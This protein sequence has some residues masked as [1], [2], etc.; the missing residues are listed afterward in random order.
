M[1]TKGGLIRNIILGV[2]G[3][4]VGGYVLGLLGVSFAGYIGTV[5]QSVI[6]ACLLVFCSKILI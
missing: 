3:G 1:G 5:I 4:L 6:G 2:L